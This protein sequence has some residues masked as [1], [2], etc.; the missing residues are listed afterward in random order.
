MKFYWPGLRSSSSFSRNTE[1]HF[2][3]P[4]HRKNVKVK[5]KKFI[6]SKKKK[7]KIIE[8]TIQLFSTKFVLLL[9][10]IF[11]IWKAKRVKRRTYFFKKSWY[12]MNEKYYIFHSF[13]IRIWRKC[14]QTYLDR[15]QIS[16]HLIPSL[17][18]NIF[19]TIFKDQLKTKL[20]HKI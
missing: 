6:C 9:K 8:R 17:S 7:K 11:I 2:F 15:D 14:R 3:L 5:K 12:W 10:Y 1:I 4:R 20:Q 16:N 13:S 18:K 19:Q